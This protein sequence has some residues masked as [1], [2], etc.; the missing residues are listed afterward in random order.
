MACAA[1]QNAGAY[2]V[3]AAPCRPR[4]GGPAGAGGHG[5]SGAACARR[6]APARAGPPAEGEAPAARAPPGPTF[7]HPVS[8]Q[9]PAP[10][11][12]QAEVKTRRAPGAGAAGPLRL[13]RSCSEADALKAAEAAL[14]G[15]APG[16]RGGGGGGGGGL[17]SWG[18]AAPA[19]AATATAAATAVAS[20]ST[21]GGGGQ[22]LYVADVAGAMGLGKFVALMTGLL[23]GALPVVF[24]RKRHHMARGLI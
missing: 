17:F 24:L 21:G 19:A 5:G 15:A 18:R 22:A 7:R 2:E 8:P 3:G 23:A 20:A 4:R 12:R 9:P 1:D 14:R 10:P 13:Y 11:G 6:G 16:G